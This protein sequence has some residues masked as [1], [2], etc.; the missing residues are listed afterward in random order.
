MEVGIDGRQQREITSEQFFD[1]K[2]AT[3][4]PD[5]SGL[6]VTAPR[7]PNKYF[8]IWKISASTRKVEPL[9]KDPE[10]SS[11]LSLTA[12][13]QVATTQESSRISGIQL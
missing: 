4:L 12:G 1:L 9:T 2:S 6:L 3:W 11:V 7:I 10:T 13:N 8:R 5:Q